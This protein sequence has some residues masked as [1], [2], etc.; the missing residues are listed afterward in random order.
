MDTNKQP[1]AEIKAMKRSRETFVT[2]LR[3]M[4]IR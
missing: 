1:Q 2:V 4:L 3:S